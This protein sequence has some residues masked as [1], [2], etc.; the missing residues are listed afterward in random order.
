VK[1]INAKQDAHNI[2]INKVDGFLTCKTKYHFF[3]HKIHR[4]SWK[5]SFTFLIQKSKYKLQ[6][7]TNNLL[8]P[9]CNKTLSKEFHSEGFKFCVPS[10]AHAYLEL[11]SL[12]RKSSQHI[13]TISAAQNIPVI[14]SGKNRIP[15][16]TLLPTIMLQT[17]FL[18]ACSQH[19]QLKSTMPSEVRCAELQKFLHPKKMVAPGSF[20]I[21]V[22]FYQSKHLYV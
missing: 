20:K 16:F 9:Q 8:P 12:K 6:C 14:V 11:L 15:S 13:S 5:V 19:L 2:L 7:A 10:S 1:I 3:P 17:V 4:I 22:N 21:L 18:F